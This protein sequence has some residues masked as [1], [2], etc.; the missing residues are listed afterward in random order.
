MD[1]ALVESH[2]VLGYNALGALALGQA[3][4]LEEGDVNEVAEEALVDPEHLVELLDRLGLVVGLEDRGRD[5]KD[6]DRGGPMAI[7]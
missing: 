3:A 2:G 4:G 5:L 7:S 1:E 6:T